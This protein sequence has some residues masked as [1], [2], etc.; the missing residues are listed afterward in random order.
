MESK[1]DKPRIKISLPKKNG[2]ISNNDSLLIPKN[3]EIEI[4]QSG[5]ATPITRKIIFK[6]SR[7]IGDALMLSCGIRD[8]KLLFPHIE[9]NVNTNF[10]ELFENNPYITRTIKKGDQGVEFYKTGYPI[11]NNVNGSALH[12][13]TG[14]LLDMIA[15]ADGYEPLGM[16]IGEFTAAFARGDVGDPDMGN[17]EKN[18]DA[19][20]PY[21]SLKKKYG[22][23]IK[24]GGLSFLPD[25][26]RNK[27][28]KE[29][30]FTDLFGRKRGDIFLTDEE[31]NDNLIKKLYG[32]QTKYWVLAPGGKS[33]CTTKIWDWRRFQEV[34][35]FFEDRIKFVVIGKSDHIVERLQNVIDLTD[36]FNKDLRG[37]IKLIYHA[38]GGVGGVSFLMHM[39]AAVP[40]KEGTSRKPFVGIYGA[41]EP[42][43]FTAYTN[44]QILHS[45][46]VFSC[47]PFGGCWQ[48]RVI[49]LA[50]SQEGNKRLCHKPVS[51]DG[52]MIPACMD[53]ITSQD[54]IRAIEKYYDGDMISYMNPVT[55]PQ[56]KKIKNI[57]SI[58]DSNKSI[59]ELNMLASL[60]SPGGGEQSALMLA[61]VLRNA[62]W[63]V[64]FYPW[65]KVHEDYS[66]YKIE[67]SSFTGSMIDN[68]KEGLPLLFYGN[69]Q[70]GTFLRDG[71]KIVNKSSGL[72]V[73]INYINAG[74]PKCDWLNATGKLLGVIFQNKEK[75]NEFKRDQIG[76]Q[77]TKLINLFGAIDL[78]TCLNILPKKRE[79]NEELVIL[80]HCTSDWRKYVTEESSRTGDKIHLWQKNIFK[81][82]D[83][84]F[85]SRFL[86]DTKNTRFEFMQAHKELVQAFPD[87]PRM[88]FHKW[89]SIPVTEF[90]ATGHLYLYRTSNAWR[91]Q[92]PR[93]VAEALAA[94]LPVLSEPRDGTK[95][96]MDFGNIGFSCIDYDGFLYAIKLLQRKEDYRF[97]MGINAKDW[98]R[99]NLDPRDWILIIE[100]ILG[101]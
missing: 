34:I 81:E 65:D 1:K 52:R 84:K 67:K 3:E 7:A 22:P 5:T 28:N 90:L 30:K 12:F 51:V 61:S 32:D 27:L 25:E 33:D 10:P 20:E 70:V 37:L 53:S 101:G 74:L 13:S 44:H 82:P 95:D 17:E 76:F 78:E 69:D 6:H 8:F 93:V 29:V 85:Y 71:E 40:P 63:R 14:F 19:C 59:K 86:K 64:N 31:K 36:K 68:M 11:I 77:N 26:I 48:S 100:D 21:I 66:K 58:V 91:D 41:R 43:T 80:K 45:N 15:L 97:K 79:K 50:K 24:N 72:I 89:N 47:S 57:V 88:I 60:S 55:S 4:I 35:D 62:G 92:Y 73:G 38:D 23:R 83:T 42:T 2:L 56:V 94:G 49:P 9:I 39:A 87:E 96:R 54:V 46:G 99:K 16:S 18:P 75:L 98:A